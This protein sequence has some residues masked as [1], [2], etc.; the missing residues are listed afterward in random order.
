MDFMKT[1]FENN[2]SID[3]IPVDH[4][5]PMNPAERTSENTYSFNIDENYNHPTIFF[6]SPKILQITNSQ[7]PA[8]EY[9]ENDLF[10]SAPNPVGNK[11]FPFEN[12]DL[13]MELNSN[14]RSV[15]TEASQIYPDELY[16]SYQWDG[17]NAG[18]V[19][20]I[21]NLPTI[22]QGTTFGS[23]MDIDYACCSQVKCA[24]HVRHSS[25]PRQGC[26]LISRHFYAVSG[27]WCTGHVLAVVGTQPDFQAF[28]GSVW[29]TE[30][31]ERDASGQRQGRSLIFRH[32]WKVFGHGVL[33]T[34]GTCLTTVGTPPD[35]SAFVGSHVRDA[36]WLQKGQ[37]LIFKQFWVVSGTRCAGQVQDAAGTHPDFQV[38]SGTLRGGH[39]QDVAGT[40]P[41]FHIFLGHVQDVIETQFDLQAFLHNFL[42]DD[43]QALIENHPGSVR[44]T[45]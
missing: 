33:A 21:T 2:Q 10:H 36:S 6:T 13:I 3:L 43:V 26:S 9:V 7:L 23:I 44:V 39:V 24:S 11:C 20:L 15:E 32:F 35:F 29:V 31:H 27:T 40:H 25:V 42:G 19:N 4:C 41:D 1:L 14:F 8:V 45:A 16:F 18:N 5:Q 37:S 12:L 22:D 17:G 30:C 38:V 28:L 34:F